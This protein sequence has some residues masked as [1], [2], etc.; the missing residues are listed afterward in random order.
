M[1][2]HPV[3]PAPAIVPEP[4]KAA[5][6]KQ[7]QATAPATIVVS[8]PENAKLTIDDNATTS[9]SA[10]RTFVT[11]ALTAGKSYHYNV[12]VEYVQDGKPVVATKKVDVV[13]GN[14]TKVNFIEEA[15]AGR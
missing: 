12:K 15:V 8:V 4:I 9:T 10:Q 5:P 2:A 11:P 14:E 7:A 6:A 3:T 1:P 13:A